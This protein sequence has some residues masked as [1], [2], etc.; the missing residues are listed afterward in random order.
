[1]AISSIQNKT[2]FDKIDA[3]FAAKKSSEAT[4]L[5]FGAMLFVAFL[6]YQF[7]FLETDKNIKITESKLS[8][9]KKKVNEQKQYLSINTPARL[10]QLK[11][12][13][14]Q[15][16]VEY[17]NTNYKISYVDNTLTE[18]SYLL[19]DDENW[20][21]FVDDISRL[22]KKYNVEIKEIAN[23]FYEPTFQKITHVVEV[24]VVSQANFSN[25]MK[26]LNEIEES[27]LVIDV[28]GIEIEKPEDKL[29]GVFKIAV[30]GM[31]Y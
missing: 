29:K 20:A 21:S 2:T 7:V 18:L 12:L 3:Y 6:V 25:M 28:H 24:D 1:M 31:K 22:A 19:F 13:V 10:V 15:K 23:K 9:V 16:H 26:F 17:D 27:Q 14:E 30:W 4:L 8:A 5:Y 11:K